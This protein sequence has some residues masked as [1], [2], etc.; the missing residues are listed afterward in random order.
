MRFIIQPWTK[1]VV[2]N[3]GNFS[4]LK[5]AFQVHNQ[6]VKKLAIYRFPIPAIPC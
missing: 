5:Y 1:L 2:T 3:Y 4:H 6:A